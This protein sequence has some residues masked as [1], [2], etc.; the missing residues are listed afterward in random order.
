MHHNRKTKGHVYWL[1][2]VDLH[3]RKDQSVSDCMHVRRVAIIDNM[4]HAR[5][6]GGAIQP[7]VTTRTLDIAYSPNRC[8]S[9]HCVWE[10]AKSIVPVEMSKKFLDGENLDI[11]R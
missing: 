11:F 5:R 8:L 6:V 10:N 2:A 9:M 4:T 7:T 1:S 3:P